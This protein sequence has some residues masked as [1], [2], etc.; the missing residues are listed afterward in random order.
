MNILILGFHVDSTVH[1]IKKINPNWNI[2]WIGQEWQRKVFDDC[3][4]SYE[5]L[6][7][8]HT[9]EE[10]FAGAFQEYYQTVFSEFPYY[11]RMMTRVSGDGWVDW[12]FQEYINLFNLHYDFFA[13]LFKE[14]KID[15]VLFSNLA[16]EGFDCMAY[17]LAKA[18]GI[19]VL[20]ATQSPFPN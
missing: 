12:S 13:S 5:N 8:G 18:I 3:E 6:Q 2:T 16:H 7:Y 4:F 15:F 11:M 10:P 9:C 14:R 19:K 1:E 17:L 20:M